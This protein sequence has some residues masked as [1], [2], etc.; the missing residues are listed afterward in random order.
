MPVLNCEAVNCIY[1]K[2]ELCSKGDIM[3]GGKQAE[4]SAETC[5]ESFKEIADGS[6]S[7]ST[8]SGCATIHVDCKALECSFN[9]D[10]KCS[11]GAID[12]EGTQANEAK[13]TD[14]GTFRNKHR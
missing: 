4:K 9:K 7:N 10:E 3:V 6:M 12:I 2:E 5:C 11:A 14:C 13:E 1:N 8:G